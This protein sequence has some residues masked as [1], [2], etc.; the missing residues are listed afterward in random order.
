MYSAALERMVAWG[1]IV[2]CC[3]EVMERGREDEGEKMRMNKYLIR[4][5]CRRQ[6]L[7]VLLQVAARVVLVNNTQS[8]HAVTKRSNL[9]IDI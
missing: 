8:R 4:L 1:K 7:Q 3:I 5:L 9:V 6:A 2:S